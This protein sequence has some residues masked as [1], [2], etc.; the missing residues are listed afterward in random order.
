MWGSFESKRYSSQYDSDPEA[1]S[2]LD[3]GGE[4]RTA[5]PGQTNQARIISGPVTECLTNGKSSLTSGHFVFCVYWMDALLA[6]LGR[7]V[8][9]EFRIQ[10][11][12]GQPE[13]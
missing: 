9:G 1:V 6:Y 12:H 5:V 11:R 2:G 4:G 8:M 3:L 13:G 7:A 10:P